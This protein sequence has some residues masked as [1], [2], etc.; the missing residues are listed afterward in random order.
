MDRRE[1]VF[2]PDPVAVVTSVAA[3]VGG[4]ANA[5]SLVVMSSGATLVTASMDPNAARGVHVGDAAQVFLDGSGGQ[6]G[7]VVTGV[8]VGSTVASTS[9]TLKPLGA[10]PVS[11][12]GADVRVVI[13]QRAGG[14]S[15]L[16]VPGSAVYSRGN[17]QTVVVVVTRGGTQHVVPV[18]VGPV[19]GGFVAV[20]PAP[21]G[22]GLKLGDQVVVSGPGLN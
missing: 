6:V 5:A 2:V 3:R 9:V 7:A 15:T 14:E 1:V 10:V 22:A 16:S 11:A 19:V 13:T 20:T 8:V 21:G 4:S 18:T 17:G 12:Q